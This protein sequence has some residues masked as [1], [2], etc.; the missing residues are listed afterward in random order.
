MASVSK[1]YTSLR[2]S[3][4]YYE[5]L[6]LR[7]NHKSTNRTR[8]KTETNIT[9]ATIANHETWLKQICMFGSL[10]MPRRTRCVNTSLHTVKQSNNSP[11]QFPEV[12]N[13]WEVTTLSGL[14]DLS[15][16]LDL[17]S[18]E[19]WDVNTHSRTGPETPRHQRLQP[20]CGKAD[21]SNEANMRAHEHR[22]LH[23]YL[24]PWWSWWH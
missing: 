10:N 21:H 11:E 22:A 23:A 16:T 4:I 6:L 13:V 9:S 20:V 7:E 18:L 8:D 17:T 12:S 1:H 14:A 24:G 15:W 3:C 19:R 5:L 2:T